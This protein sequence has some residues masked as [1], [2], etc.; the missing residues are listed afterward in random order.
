LSEP[1]NSR[2]ALL[3]GVPAE[4]VLARLKQ[5]AGK[6]LESGKFTHPESSSALAANAFGWFIDRPSLIPLFP[7]GPSWDE[8]QR[9]EVEYCARFPWAGGRHPW[10]DAVVEA[11]SELIG[12]ESKRFEPFRDRKH[13]VLSDAYDRPVWGENMGPFERMRDQLRA[14]G[15]LFQTLDA[16][17]LV[18]HAFGLVTDARRK[19]KKPHLHYLYA[20]PVA[21]AGKPISDQLMQTHRQEIGQFATAVAGAD[22][23]F[24]A[25]SYRE[26]LAT[27]TGPDLSRHAGRLREVF[28]P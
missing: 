26:W 27:W 4:R 22:V 10:L 6:E 1:G 25:C 12:V 23:G 14:D 21:R 19:S 11:Q 17:Q 7:G 15:A 24:S 20:E 16:A 28:A 13:A 5:A 3:E 8:V 2:P 18:K 9:V